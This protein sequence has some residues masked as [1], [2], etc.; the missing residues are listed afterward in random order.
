MADE[1]TRI[2]VP[3]DVNRAWKPPRDLSKPLTPFQ[4]TLIL[5][6]RPTGTRV[7][8]A[9]LHRTVQLPCSIWVATLAPDGTTSKLILRMNYMIG[10][11]EKEAAILPYLAQAGLPVPTALAG[12]VIDPSQPEA[13]AMTVLNVLPGQSFLDLDYTATPERVPWAMDQILHGVALIHGV[14]PFLQ[15]SPA[16]QFLPQKSLRSELRAILE[17]AGPWLSQSIFH[18]ATASID[19]VLTATETPLT[20]SSG[21]YNQGNFLFHGDHLTGLVDFTA[22]TF[23]DPHIGMAMYLIYSWDPFDRAG[24]VERYL[25]QQR[26]SFGD[27]APRL[28]LRCLRTLQESLPVRGGEETRDEWDFETLADSRQRVLTLLSRAINAMDP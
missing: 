25:E 12:P 1:Q 4:E 15:R 5:S 17:R 28:A 3:S 26:L 27:F 18:Q 7:V 19:R 13:G 2:P 16:A 20:F 11:V 9:H 24:I 22:P 21:D 8:S 6:V 14:T 10:G 23:E